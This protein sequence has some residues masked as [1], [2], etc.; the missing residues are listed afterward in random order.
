LTGGGCTV[1]HT[2]DTL[3]LEDHYD[4]VHIDV[5]LLPICNHSWTLRELPRLLSPQ[6]IIPMHYDTYQVTD[7][8]RHW[9][10][11]SPEALRATMAYPERLV[12]LEQGE[13]FTFQD[14][15]PFSDQARG[16]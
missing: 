2:G 13:A 3:L 15:R 1:F 6:V 7:R 5:L 14:M 11:G 4:L 9:T 10:V 16:D 12:V 8:N